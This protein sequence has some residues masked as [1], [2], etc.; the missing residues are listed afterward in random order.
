[1]KP[2]I[3]LAT[4][5]GHF[6]LLPTEESVGL[7]DESVTRMPLISRNVINHSQMLANAFMFFEFP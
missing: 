1:L 5:S 3:S 2:D 6:N 4:K 7:S